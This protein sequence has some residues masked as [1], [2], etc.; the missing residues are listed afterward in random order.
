VIYN[1]TVKQFQRAL[2]RSFERAGRP[3]VR[4]ER[5]AAG[6]PA[7]VVASL[8]LRIRVSPFPLLQNVTC[9]FE[10]LDGQPVEPAQLEPLRQ[11]LQDSLGST[12]TL[13]SASAACFLLIGTVMLS[14]PLLLM[15]RHMDTIVKVVSS[16]FA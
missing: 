15:A 6:L 11:S 4:E 14:A 7:W 1:I 13:P 12:H 2:V 8:G 9:Y 10:R 5:I 3:V 16:L